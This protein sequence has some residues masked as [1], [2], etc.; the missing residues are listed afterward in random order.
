MINLVGDGETLLPEESIELIT[1]LI[2]AGN[3]VSVVTNGTLTKRIHK[4]IERLEVID[5][6]SSILFSLSFHYVELKKRNLLETFFDNISYLEENNISYTVRMVLGADTLELSDEIKSISMEKLGAYPQVSIARKE[7]PDGSIEIFADCTEEEYYKIGDSFNS[8][9]FELGKREFNKHP[10]DFCYAGQW[11]FGL[12]FTTGRYTKCLSN[13]EMDFNFFENIEDELILEPV[14][15]RCK[16]PYCTCSNYQTW[17]VIPENRRF[18]SA[19]I[20]DRPE[21]GWIKEPFCSI[22]SQNLAETNQCLTLSE[23]ETADRKFLM[24]SYYKSIYELIKKDFV[25]Q[26][27]EDVCEKAENLL[28]QNLDYRLTWVIDLIVT[29]GY[30]LLQTGA[31]NKALEL[32]GY[33][34]KLKHY[35]DYCFVLALINMQNEMF[36]KAVDLFLEATNCDAVIKQGTNEYLAYFNI[37]VIFECTGDLENAEKYYRKC[38]NYAPAQKQLD[39]LIASKNR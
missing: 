17:G 34:N 32:S 28:L 3:Y 12:D 31:Y 19:Q 15:F 22:L 35:A 27:Y 16:R 39:G 10:S 36:D 24:R 11:L 38:K 21:A 5:K 2:K 25:E 29:Y 6:K 13:D 23:K 9:L 8:M 14:G 18:T 20:Y 4:L 37:G 30:A 7:N 33:Y 1:G 26:R